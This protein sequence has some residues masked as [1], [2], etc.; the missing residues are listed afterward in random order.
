MHTLLYMR[1]WSVALA[2][3]RP[4]SRGGH[5]AEGFPSFQ[6]RVSSRGCYF[7]SRETQLKAGVDAAAGL[8]LAKSACKS[9]EQ[10]RGLAMGWGG[11]CKTV[12]MNHEL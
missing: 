11:S 6:T 12:R 9:H 3:S 10:R 7:P 2:L 5:Q 1:S 4:L 8:R